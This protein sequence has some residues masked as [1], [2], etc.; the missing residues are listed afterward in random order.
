MTD[1]APGAQKSEST[2]HVD[3]PQIAWQ[4]G[5][6]AFTRRSWKSKQ[7]A[8]GK[9][10]PL[11]IR[12]LSEWKA[13]VGPASFSSILGQTYFCRNYPESAVSS[14]KYDVAID[15]QLHLIAAGNI[16]IQEQKLTDLELAEALQD[17]REARDEAREE[18]FPEPSDMAIANAERLLRAMYDIS[19]QRFEVYPTPDAEIAIDAPG[20]YGQSVLL[21]CESSG[22][23]LCMVDVHGEHRRARYDSTRTLPDGFMAEALTELADAASRP[24]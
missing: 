17:L 4:I 6:G 23:A 20:G 21:F 22:G 24:R 13:F 5:E 2:V 8:V 3:L 12:E 9:L 14:Q 15:L 16:S 10:D 7:E 1:G 19:P 18:G 11:S